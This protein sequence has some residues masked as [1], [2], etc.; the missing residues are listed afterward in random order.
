MSQALENISV[1]NLI[2]LHCNLIKGT[3]SNN[4]ENGENN[5]P[6]RRGCRALCRRGSKY[7]GK[8]H[9]KVKYFHNGLCIR[10]TM[11]PM[12]TDA[13]HTLEICPKDLNKNLRL[14]STHKLMNVNV[15]LK[16]L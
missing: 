14:L 1:N 15:L 6:S 8:G 13:F 4:N 10:L 11:G 7:A 2:R 12:I 3:Q 9:I 16:Y 5:I